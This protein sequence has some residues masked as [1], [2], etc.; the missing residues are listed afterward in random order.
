[1][2]PATGPNINVPSIPAAMVVARG[3]EARAP[4]II[5]AIS[6]NI[7]TSNVVLAIDLHSAKID[8]S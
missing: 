5:I 7:K 1:M 2:R 6:F 3:K 8:G 4:K